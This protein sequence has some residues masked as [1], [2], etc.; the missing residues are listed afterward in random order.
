MFRL[1]PVAGFAVHMRVFAVLF[2][3]KHVCVAGFARLVPRKMNR[4]GSN[5]TDSV[6]TVVAVLSKAFGD[7]VSAN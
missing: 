3:I 6:A 4:A 7:D 2:H 5:V 1:R